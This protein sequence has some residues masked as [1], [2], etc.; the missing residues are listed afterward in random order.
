MLTGFRIPKLL[1]HRFPCWER[2]PGGVALF[3]CGIVLATGKIKANWYVLFFRIPEKH[4]AARAV[5]GGLRWVGY[6]NPIVSEAVLTTAIQPLPIVIM[7]ALQYRI[8]QTEAAS[9]V[10]LSLMG[11][12]RLGFSSP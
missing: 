4:R 2:H 11:S 9:A 8:A 1:V 5:L 7:L 3:A 12:V 10:F 6:G